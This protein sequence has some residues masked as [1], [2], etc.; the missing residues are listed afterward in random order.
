M[1]MMGGCFSGGK[2]SDEEG[3]GK[4]GAKAEAGGPPP[5][6]PGGAPGKTAGPTGPPAGGPGGPPA[7]GPGAPPAGGPGGPPAGGPGGP[8]AAGPGGPGA[9]SAMPAGPGGPGGAVAVAPTM[10][11]AAPAA[12]TVVAPPGAT[13]KQGIYAKHAGKYDEAYAIFN[14]NLATNP[15]DALALYGKAW[16]EAERMQKPQALQT[17][18]TFLAVSKDGSKN[19]EA[20]AAVGR[21]KANPVAAAPSAA[22]SRGPAGPGGPGMP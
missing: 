5:G 2:K 14:A 8:A 9:P 12:S 11:A 19:K 21:I 6:M 16:I 10:P 20:R 1:T 17:F 18:G 4:T 7:G 22:P 13:A 15:K 3:D